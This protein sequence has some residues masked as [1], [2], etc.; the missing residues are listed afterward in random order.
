MSRIMTLR[1]STSFL[2]HLEHS[3]ILWL[4]KIL[5]EHPAAWGLAQSAKFYTTSSCPGS[6]IWSSSSRCSSE[7]WFPPLSMNGFLT[8]VFRSWRRLS[9]SRT[10]PPVLDLFRSLPSMP[11]IIQDEVQQC[12]GKLFIFSHLRSII[13]DNITSLVEIIIQ[14]VV[15]NLMINFDRR[16]YL[17][18]LDLAFKSARLFYRYRR[19]AR[20]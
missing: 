17:L 6:L 4:V 14:E 2:D 3:W 13:S 8:Y 20:S 16:V 11:S 7:R 5:R 18:V 12:G 9:S 10:C 15:I 1:S 19:Q